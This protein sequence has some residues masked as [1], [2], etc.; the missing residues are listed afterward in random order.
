MIFRAAARESSKY[1]RDQWQSWEQRSRKQAAEAGVTIINEIDR[2]PF[3]DATSSM[4]DGLRA[5]PKFGP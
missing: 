4:R 3:E 2:K 1:M 5:D